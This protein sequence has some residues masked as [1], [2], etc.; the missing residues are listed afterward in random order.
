MQGGEFRKGT[1]M[2][3]LARSSDDARVLA[4]FNNI[5]PGTVTVQMREHSLSITA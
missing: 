3:L 5:M 1:M 2:P 4:G